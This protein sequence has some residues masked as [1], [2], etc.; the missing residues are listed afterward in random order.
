MNEHILKASYQGVLNL[1]GFDLSCAVLD[2]ENRT[3][4][5]SERTIANAFGIKGSGQYWKK[6]KEETIILPEYLSATYLA[7]YISETLIKCFEES[8]VYVTLN[9]QKARGVDVKVLPEICDVYIQASKDVNQENVQAAARIAYTIM[10]G[11]ATV[12]IVAL[13]DE[14]TGYQHDR[15]QDTL[16]QILKA[17]IAEELLPWQKRFPDIY[18]KELFRLNGWDYTINGIKRRPSVI[19]KWTNSLIYEQLPQGVLAELKKRTPK[20]ESGNYMARLH[21]SLSIDV[22]EP[23]LNNQITQIITLFQLSDNMQH[24]WMQFEKLKERQHGQLELP[25][26]FDDEGHTKE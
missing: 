18:Y 26:T 19:G 11:F 22:G 1:N 2:D 4:V 12:G 16:Q 21:Q 15:E 10:K 9:N 25:F 6:K 20:S 7:P 17:Y 14:A 24:M 8:K 3:R 13:V 23:S 5:F